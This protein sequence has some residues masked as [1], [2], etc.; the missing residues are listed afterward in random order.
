MELIKNY[1]VESVHKTKSVSK[2]QNQTYYQRENV[3]EKD[4]MGSWDWHIYTA[5][6]GMAK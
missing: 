1:A 4:K 5:I 2:I 3:G 6:Y